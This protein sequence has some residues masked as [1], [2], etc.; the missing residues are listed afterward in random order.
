MI[1]NIQ[2]VSNS[3]EKMS[4]SFIELTQSAQNGVNVQSGIN[5]RIE[6][7]SALSNIL[8]EANVAIATIAEQTNLLA[9]NAS[10]EAA[11]AG[12]AGKGFAVVAYDIRKLSETSTQQSNTIGEQLTTIKNFY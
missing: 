1:G 2:S 3:M 6:Q 4:A 9:M 7:I 11:H 10:I 5:A 8:Q 12:D